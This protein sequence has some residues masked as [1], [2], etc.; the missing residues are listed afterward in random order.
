WRPRTNCVGIALDELPEATGTRFFVAEIRS[1]LI[2]PE[3]PGQI[4]L[5]LGDVAGKRRGQV[6]PERQPLAVVILEGKDPL[7]RPVLVRQEFA[8]RSRILEKRGPK[9]VEA[10][11]LV[12]AADRIQHA[13]LGRQLQRPTIAEATRQPRPWAE[14]FVV[15]HDRPAQK[16]RLQ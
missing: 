5:V 15:A 2:T 10:V 1:D 12:D 9:C 13:P 11:T 7:V 16:E 6:V 8:E 3:G 4:L 14:R